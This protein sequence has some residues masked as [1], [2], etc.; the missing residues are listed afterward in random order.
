MPGKSAKYKKLDIR[1]LSDLHHWTSEQ[2]TDVR[3]LDAQ[4]SLSTTAD[5]SNDIFNTSN[6]CPV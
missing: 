5:F 6:K 1:N 3:C 4:Q 2:F